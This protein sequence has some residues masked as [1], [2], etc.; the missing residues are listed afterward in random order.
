MQ[1]AR[2]VPRGLVVSTFFLLSS[3]YGCCSGR[4]SPTPHSTRPRVAVAHPDPKIVG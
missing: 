4:N 1:A 3:F 2:E